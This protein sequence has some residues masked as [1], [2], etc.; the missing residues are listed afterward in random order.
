VTRGRLP[1]RAGS[2]GRNGGG[3]AAA[4]LPQWIHQW[5]TKVL[6]HFKHANSSYIMP[7]MISNGN[8]MYKDY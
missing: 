4:V 2:P 1:Q 6:W 8:G 7:E 5:I 3:A